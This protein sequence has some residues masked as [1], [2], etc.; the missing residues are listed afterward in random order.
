[1]QEQGKEKALL[2]GIQPPGVSDDELRESLE[3]L[4][5]LAKT[6]GIEILGNVVQKRTR[7]DR[8]NYFG[9]GKIKEVGETA[10][11]LGAGLIIADDE[12]NSLQHRRMEEGIEL[13]VIDRTSL[14]LEIFSTRAS[15]REGKLQVE[16]AQLQYS[17]LRLAGGYFGLSRQR[18]GIGLKG[19]GET[20]IESDR[21]ELRRRIRLLEEELEKVVQDRH[22]QRR[23]RTERYAP[24]FAL[25]G[26]TNA[27]KSTLLNA[28]SGSETLVHNGLFT[29]LDPTARRVDLPAGR[30]CIL[31]DTVGFIKK[32][33]HGLVKAFRATL[34]DV[35]NSQVLVLVADISNPGI[36]EQVAAVRQVL[37]EMNIGPDHRFL[38]VLNKTDRPHALQPE[39][40]EHEFPGALIVSAKTGVGLDALKTRMSLIMDP[41]FVKV[42]ILLPANSPLVRE[43]F[44]LGTV[45]KQ[46]W[47]EEG[48]LM[49]IEVPKK[50]LPKLEPYLRDQNGVE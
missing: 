37:Q 22:V 15:S 40:L 39:V 20:K 46:E 13:P 27:G 38:L 2:V 28:L 16:L 5:E 25:V 35:V 32:L 3:E 8:N 10:K 7:V 33:P 12:L 45:E 26:Y 24:L 48:V 29:T 19:P 34:E 41:L 43:L 31:S 11:N 44:T 9:K 49:T 18:G 4:A 30:A 21:R 17:L 14:I 36:R 6:A 47:G 50:I 1:M 42:N 23:M